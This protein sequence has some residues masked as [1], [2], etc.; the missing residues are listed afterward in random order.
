MREP[1]ARGG[2]RTRPD[3][4]LPITD[5]RPGAEYFYH[6]DPEHH[7]EK[8]YCSHSGV[9]SLGRYSSNAFAAGLPDAAKVFTSASNST[10]AIPPFAAT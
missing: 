3:V 9:R 4:R 1:V 5:T 8:L 7:D 6:E 10:W 2:P